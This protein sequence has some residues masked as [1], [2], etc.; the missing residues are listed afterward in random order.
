[1][2]LKPL[3]TQ[4][5]TSHFSSISV[6]N[7][8]WLLLSPPL[9]NCRLD[10]YE[11][12]NLFENQEDVFTWLIDI[13]NKIKNKPECFSCIHPSRFKRIGLFYEALFAFYLRQG[14][15]DGVCPYRLV[16]RNIQIIDGNK[17]LG[18]LDFLVL[19][20]NN[21]AIHIETAVKFYLLHHHEQDDLTNW[22]NWVGPNAK[23]RLDLKLGRM[24]NHQLSLSRNHISKEKIGSMFNF[25]T[26][27]L[28]DFD[29]MVAKYYLGG[30]VYWHRDVSTNKLP[31]DSNPRQE[32]S[33]W[34]YKGELEALLSN[35]SFLWLPLQ[36][37]Q[38]MSGIDTESFYNL[39]ITGKE[40]KEL[41]EQKPT[42]NCDYFFGSLPLQVLYLHKENQNSK[43][44]F[45]MIVND[46]WPNASSPSRK[47]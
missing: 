24:L 14:D 20:Q 34:L 19:D 45:L 38:W 46:H 32:T 12:I 36:K 26:S 11:Q 43:P 39:A 1:M 27:N 35:A 7:L 37:L 16:G 40:L 13:D 3:A 2:T 6:Q 42:E 33:E 10:G 15:L 4:E 29:S 47:I 22:C 28:F 9:F 23:D 25:S 44:Q 5:I 41:I 31:I 21:T 30:R 17:T 8:A 18:E